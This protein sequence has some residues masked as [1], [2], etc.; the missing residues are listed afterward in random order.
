MDGALYGLNS[1]GSFWG[2]M[3][4]ETFHDMDFL[5]TVADSYLYHRQSRKPNSENYHELLLVYVDDVLYFLH[6]PQ[7]IMDALALTYDMKDKSVGPSNIYLGAKIKKYYV[8]S[9]KSHWRM[10]I[11]QYVKNPIKIVEGL[12]KDD[13]R[14]LRK[15]KSAGKQPL[16]N[17]YWPELEQSNELI[18]ELA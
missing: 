6:N 1:S 13:Y 2:E 8:R 10:S 9:G 7:L 4:A 15:V 14:Q 12:L 11:T 16:T 18:P 3:F 5:P 17:G